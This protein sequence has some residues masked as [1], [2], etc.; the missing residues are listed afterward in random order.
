M[1]VGPSRE[2]FEL[3]A[4]DSRNGLIVTGYSVEGTLAR[5]SA[6][7]SDLGIRYLLSVHK[8]RQW[9]MFFPNTSVLQNFFCPE[10]FVHFLK[11]LFL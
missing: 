1:Q 8:I 11:I 4:P 9:T 7:R 2:L 3:W 5:V 6:K 10:L